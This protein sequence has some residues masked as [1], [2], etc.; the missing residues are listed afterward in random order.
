MTLKKVAQLAGVSHTTVSLVINNAKGS[1]VSSRTRQRVLE[2]AR[3]LDYNPNLLAQRLVSGKSNS[4][5]LFVP[6]TT[7]I[8]RN[9]TM[10]ELVAGVQD[11]LNEKGF[12]LVLFSGGR[13][14][15]KH[16]PI[17]QIAR[18]NTLDG[19][20]IFNTRD[21]THEYI[22]SYI[23]NLNRLEFN[24]VAV[25]YYNG[26]ADINYVGIDSEK[27]ATKTVSYMTFLG[28]R[29]IAMLAGP[30]D[31]VVSTRFIRGYQ[32]AFDNSRLDVNQK[33]LVFCRYDQQEAYEKTQ[34]LLQDVP[35]ISCFVLAGYEMAPG[36]M[37][38]IKDAGYRIPE[39]ISIVAYA[40]N[41]TLSLFEPPLTAVRLPYYEMGRKAA[42]IVVENPKKKKHHIFESQLIVRDSTCGPPEHH[43]APTQNSEEPKK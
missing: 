21:T 26:N 25:A 7:S 28:H 39:D 13:N 41:D 6:Y 11:V 17:S 40:D 31:A 3:Q 10:V 32:K 20:I 43:G 27:N 2:A 22:E 42:E 24:F 33:L 9:Y 37:K 29:N 16:R 34:Q 14:L 18:Q 19:L 30:A 4:I 1:R 36:C 23:K 15:Y 5:G 35:D 38:A 12:D 8:F